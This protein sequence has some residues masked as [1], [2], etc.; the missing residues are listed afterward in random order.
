MRFAISLLTVLA[1]ASV[2]GTVL[3]QNQP[4]P[5]YIIEFGPFWFAFFEMLGLFD[6]YHSAWFLLILGFLVLSTSLC[7]W[8]NTPGFLREMKGYREKA[9]ESSLA[10]MS[11]SQEVTAD[12]DPDACVR[13]LKQSGF[14]VKT[15][16]RDGAILV[17]AKRGVGNKLGYFF[18]HIAMVVICLGGLLDGNLPLKIGELFGRIV[19]ETRE[20]PQS[21][22]PPQSRLSTSN[23]SFR[24]NVTIAENSSAD[25]VF[26][27]AGQGYLVQELPF[28]VTLK[29]F[30]VD[31]YS[32]GMPKLF[33]SDVVITDKKTGKT[34]EATVKVNHPLDVDGIS[35]YQSSFGDGGSPVQFEA[36]N[37][38]MPQQSRPATLQAR[39]MN[40]QPLTANGQSYVLEMGELKVFNVQDMAANSTV[41][42]NKTF[43]QSLSQAQSVKHDKTLSNVG[44]SVTFK[45]RDAQGQAREYHTYMSPITLE[46]QPY[47]V[48]GVRKEVGEPFSYL[49]FPLDSDMKLDTFMR[50]YT[51]LK[52]P[53]SFEEIA[54]ITADRALSQEAISS[55]MRQQFQESVRWVLQRFSEGGFAAL[56]QFLDDKVPEDKRQAVAQTYI[57]ILQGA[58]IDAMNVAQKRAGL[59]PFAFNEA[60]YRFLLDSLVAAS[61]VPDLGSPVLLKMSGFD[62]VQASGLQITRS[63]GKSIVYLGSVLLVLGILCMF[64]IRELRVW[65]L[66]KSGRVRIAMASNR[67]NPELARDFARHTERIS[68]LNRGK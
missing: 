66:I 4:Y 33:A 27:N 65:V 47:L 36:W 5:N 62:Q 68:D 61:V 24:G 55:P 7:I 1:I 8:R 23:I 37:L 59:A 35:I 25:V 30:H 26:I 50:L 12:V 11:H 60:N 58:V 2:I 3:Q 15:H 28:I 46:G 41:A 45:L 53:S 39:S 48:S 52:D 18:A 14:A 44:P 54:R 49:R 17:A 32:T 43:A 40:S 34:R 6:V 20:L 31:F 19:P 29:K 56:E 22:I 21:Q 63:P 16:A 57:K 64:Y 10:A 42:V 9:S 67:K 13:Y 38:D 51:V